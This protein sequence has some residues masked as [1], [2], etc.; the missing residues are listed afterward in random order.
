V[1]SATALPI[2][3]DTYHAGVAE[4]ALDAGADLINDIH[5]LRRDPA[6]ARLA[7]VSGA[8]VVAMHNQRGR[9]ACDVVEGVR[10]GF[11]ETLCAASE[12]G[13]PAER[14]ILDPGFGFGWQPQQNFEMLRRLPELHDFGLPLLLGVSR[15]ST[16]GMLLDLPVQERLEGT[17]AA[18]TLSVA[19]G[20]DVVRVHDVRSMARVVRLADAVVRGS[21]R[22][23]ARDA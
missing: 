15:K 17:A 12:A 6:M 11:L 13:L 23:P 7:A 8:P 19:G 4:R 20:A 21:W 3:V 16:I 22:P 10:A 18:V 9:P 14:L 5:G 1:R 2:S